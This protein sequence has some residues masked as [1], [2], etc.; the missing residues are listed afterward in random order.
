[1]LK[2]ALLF[3]GFAALAPLTGWVIGVAFYALIEAFDHWIA[4]DLLTMVGLKMV[5]DGWTGTQT[6]VVIDG[7]RLLVLVVAAIATSI[8]AVAVGITLPA[9]EVNVLMAASVI[10][11]VTFLAAISGGFLGRFAGRNMGRWAE[12]LGGIFLILIG[13]RI[14]LEHTY[15]ALVAG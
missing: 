14:V 10:G 4:F 12:I 8:D 3:G 11:L 2:A 6:D 9:F 5:R 1:L 13:V 15:W 7:F